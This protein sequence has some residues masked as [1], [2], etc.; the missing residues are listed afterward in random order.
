MS[1]DRLQAERYAQAVVQA[2]VE[3]WQT[4]LAQAADAI[5]SDADLSQTLS[6]NSLDLDK[7]LDALQKALPEDVP[8]EVQNLLKL[9]VQEHDLDLLT[10]VSNALADVS[11]GRQ[12]PVRAEITSAVELTDEEKEQLRQ[13]ISAEHGVDLLFDFRV[14][15]SLLGGLRVRVGDRLIDTSVASRL[16]A[17]RESLTSVVR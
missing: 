6:D 2:M 11:S 10:E 8:P 3:R 13:K 17:M 14:D 12:A 4:V 15:P 9:L 16:G 7:R 1:N 5:R